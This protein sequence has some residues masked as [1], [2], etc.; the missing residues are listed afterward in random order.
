[1]SCQRGVWECSIRKLLDTLELHQAQPQ[2]LLQPTEPEISGVK[3]TL[4]VLA[5]N[6]SGAQGSFPC[7]GGPGKW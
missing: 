5:A 3:F 2:R 6:P 1:M 7:A 4:L